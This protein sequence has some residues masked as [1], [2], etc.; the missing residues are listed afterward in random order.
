[1]LKRLSGRLLRMQAPRKHT[2][3]ARTHRP[4]LRFQK[5]RHKDRQIQHVSGERL[6]HKTSS[7]I[8]ER[9]LRAARFTQT[10]SESPASVNVCIDTLPHDTTRQHP[11]PSW[12]RARRTPWRP[13]LSLNRTRLSRFQS[14]L[15]VRGATRC[16]SPRTC[17]SGYFNPRSPCGER[18]RCGITYAALTA[19]QSSLPVR[20]A[21]PSL[22]RITTGS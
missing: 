9:V 13:R 5:P 12:A 3:T 21:T 8:Q 2:A 11:S 1:M 16:A 18:R 17:S 6:R 15:P 10:L 19:F 4:S 20:G 14:S 7:R 22:S